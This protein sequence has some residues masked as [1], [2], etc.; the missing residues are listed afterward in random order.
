[1]PT[2]TDPQSAALTDEPSSLSGWVLAV[3]RTISAAGVD[4]A[5]LMRDAGIDASVLVDPEARVPVEKMSQLW[6]KAEQI[7]GDETLGLRVPQHVDTSTLFDFNALIQAA[8]SV[9][10]GWHLFERY[11]PVLST[12]LNIRLETLDSSLEQ[13]DDTDEAL[14]AAQAQANEQESDTPATYE[15]A[16]VM[17]AA[18]PIK[19]ITLAGDATV[20]TLIGNLRSSSLNLDIS[21][22]EL[23]RS[24]P[25]DPAE[26]ERILGA[27]VSYNQP[28]LCIHFTSTVP[29]NQPQKSAN[30]LLEQ[31]MQS[32][33]ENYLERM[34]G[35][36]FAE[37]V[38][39]EIIRVMAGQEPSL[40]SIA[41][42]L[43][44]SSRTLQRRLVSDGCSY[45]DLVNEVRQGM[46]LR[47]VRD[48]Q[49][50]FTDIAYQ[51][52]FR[53]ASNFSRVFRRWFGATPSKFRPKSR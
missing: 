33:L 24:E 9:A 49:A 30:P 42:R 20:A 5:P 13:A 36:N 45:R 35:D 4:P 23:A 28:R 50:N 48:T 6:L 39:R 27:S 8:P 22:V 15:Y 47:L 21:H 2:T 52:G 10:E 53:D 31:A 32:V 51:L 37:Q 18:R 14:S 7:S 16:I 17:E 3:M 43:H 40:E 12:G 26:F 25:K 46:A 1:M 41:S 29:L 38:R 19:T 44:M 11:M 34:Q